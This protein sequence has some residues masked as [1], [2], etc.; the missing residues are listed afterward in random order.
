MK[1]E[2]EDFD[3]EE[4]KIIEKSIIDALIQ[5][6]E[7]RTQEGQSLESEFASRINTILN[8]LEAVISS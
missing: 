8:L 4:W 3:E 6:D 5:V 2:K 1:T 7:F